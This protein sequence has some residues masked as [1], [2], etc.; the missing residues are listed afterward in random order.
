MTDTNGRHPSTVYRVNLPG[1]M[2]AMPAGSEMKV[3]ITGRS[4]PKKT[5]ASPCRSNQSWAR[6]TSC[7]RTRR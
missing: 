3:R 2:R 5:A 6:S 7:G 1:F 4:R